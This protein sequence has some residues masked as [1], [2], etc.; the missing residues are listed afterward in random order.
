[1]TSSRYKGE[2]YE[3]LRPNNPW[4]NNGRPARDAAPGRRRRGASSPVATQ[5]QFVDDAK[6][7]MF[8]R[9]AG[10]VPAPTLR[11]MRQADASHR[12]IYDPDIDAAIDAD[13]Y[14]ALAKALL[15]EL[16]D[17]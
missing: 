10:G 4:D 12:G 11:D 2:L 6:N 17:L 14:E 9:G 16:G 13:D 7:L 1:M 3:V 5:V 8:F 15:R